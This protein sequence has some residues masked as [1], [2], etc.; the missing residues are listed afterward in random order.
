MKNH[1]LYNQSQSHQNRWALE[2]YKK[3]IRYYGK[4]LFKNSSRQKNR[5]RKN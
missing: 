5:G 4:K 1:Y 2:N 3:E